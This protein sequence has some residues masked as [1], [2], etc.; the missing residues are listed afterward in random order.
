MRLQWYTQCNLTCLTSSIFSSMQNDREASRQ[1]VAAPQRLLEVSQWEAARSSSQWNPFPGHKKEWSW[2]ARTETRKGKNQR[3]VS[4]EKSGAWAYMI[5]VH[6]GDQD[7]DVLPPPPILPPSS[8]S[9]PPTPMVQYFREEPKVH[10]WRIIRGMGLYMNIICIG[11]GGGSGTRICSIPWCNTLREEPKEEIRGGLG[12]VLF[13]P[14]PPLPLRPSLPWCST[15]WDRI[16]VKGP[17]HAVIE[18]VVRL[19]LQ[20]CRPWNCGCTWMAILQS[21]HYARCALPTSVVGV[22]ISSVTC[23]KNQLLCASLWSLTTSGYEDSYRLS[24]IG[25]L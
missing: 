17:L 20:G 2:G 12:Y 6:V 3:Y 9:A 11:G 16:W 19:Q 25:F 4:E 14:P 1:D 21:M 22:A 8:T 13:P 7:Q 10:I 5:Y 23:I 24:T 18:I 15:Y